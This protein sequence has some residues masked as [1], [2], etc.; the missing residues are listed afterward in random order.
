MHLSV[1][2]YMEINMLEN[3]PRFKSD[4]NVI[5]I[6]KDIYLYKN[7][8]DPKIL[9]HYTAELKALE[10]P[11]W[12]THGNYEE[13]DHANS[14]WNDKVSLD[15][16]EPEFHDALFNYFAPDYWMYEH[17]NFVR[18]K[19]GDLA[20]LDD[21]QASH[22]LDIKFPNYKV[23]LYLGDFTGGEIEFDKL[24]FE[25]APKANDLLIF[26]TDKEYSHRTKEVLSGTRYAYIDFLIYHPGYFMA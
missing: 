15:I 3:N 4:P 5:E 13:N 12:S 8:L 16:I 2:G 7:F 20:D 1:D 26:S 21:N 18:L 19:A 25:Y 23:A 22:M 11:K 10:E 9:D 14:F 17:D 24:D 6:R